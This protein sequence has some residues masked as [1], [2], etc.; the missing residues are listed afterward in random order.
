MTQDM[1]PKK[2]KFPMVS[3]PFISLCPDLNLNRTVFCGWWALLEAVGE[4][5]VKNNQTKFPAA[6]PAQ[7]VHVAAPSPGLWKA[8]LWHIRY[9]GHH[10]EHTGFGFLLHSLHNDMKSLVLPAPKHTKCRQD[11]WEQSPAF[12]ALGIQQTLQQE[13]CP[14]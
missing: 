7:W 5:N 6:A 9:P 13:E 10:R 1:G 11:S 12:S 8:N 4:R 2:H 14:A 3:S